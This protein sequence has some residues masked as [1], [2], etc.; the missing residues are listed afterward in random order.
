MVRVSKDSTKPAPAG[1]AGFAG[2][3]SVS[4]GRAPKASGVCALRSL[5]CGRRITRPYKESFSIHDP[6]CSYF[7]LISNKNLITGGWR[8][9]CVT[10]YSGLIPFNLETGNLECL[11]VSNQVTTPFKP[12]EHDHNDR[13]LVCK[14]DFRASTIIAGSAGSIRCHVQSRQGAKD[15]GNRSGCS[16]VGYLTANCQNYPT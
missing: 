12:C 7:V 4:V 16:Q 8:K 1:S 13:P 5:R 2:C 9:C 15:K 10:N 14:H 11:P 6:I 3:T